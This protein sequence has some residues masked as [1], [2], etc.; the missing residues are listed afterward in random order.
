MREERRGMEFKRDRRE[1]GRSWLRLLYKGRRWCQI[2]DSIDNMA[3]LSISGSS[4]SSKAP[5]KVSIEQ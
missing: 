5:V 1:G 3:L 2:F 4:S